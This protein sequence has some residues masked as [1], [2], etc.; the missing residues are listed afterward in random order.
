MKLNPFNP[1]LLKIYASIVSVLIT[2]E[3]FILIFIEINDKYKLLA[4]F[5]NLIIL[6]L[7]YLIVFIVAYNCKKKT[8]KCGSN[9]IIIKF[10]DLF[11]ENANKVIACNEYF[12]ST[13]D[14]ILISS[15]TLHGKVMLE[16]IDDISDFD[17][18]LDNDINCRNRII[19]NDC[20]RHLG[21]TSKYE[22]GTCFKYKDFIFVAFTKFD[23]QN[24]AYLNLPDYMYC[25][26]NFW[27]E[28]NRIYNAE[29]VVIPLMGSGITR[30]PDS[31]TITKQEQLEILINS[32]KYSNLSFSHD[33]T[34]TIVLPENLKNEISIFKI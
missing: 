34:I 29:N 21:K 23:E 17:M 14:E 9:K 13:V 26:S 5:L 30:L 28:L 31:S 19:E 33:V 12:D 25:L 8:L 20:K 1:K 11:E 3:S 15:K 24:R 2:I 4:L 6:L 16:Y 18:Q 7:V 32:L 22:L 10:G 27:N